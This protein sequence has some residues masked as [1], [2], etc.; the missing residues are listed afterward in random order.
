MRICKNCDGKYPENVVT[1]LQNEKKNNHTYIF[2]C[3]MKIITVNLW[4][5]LFEI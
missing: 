3:Y 5:Y 2:R 1:A 4:N